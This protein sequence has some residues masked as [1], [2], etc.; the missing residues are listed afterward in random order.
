MKNLKKR[1]CQLNSL[2]LVNFL[3]YGFVA[4]Q[5]AVQVFE[6][7]EFN[8]HDPFEVNKYYFSLLPSQISYLV[9]VLYSSEF[10]IALPDPRYKLDFKIADN[11]E[12]NNMSDAAFWGSFNTTI[13]D[14][15][16][17]NEA[18]GKGNITCARYYL[19]RKK[20]PS[21]V[22]AEFGI[23]ISP[24]YLA[25]YANNLKLLVCY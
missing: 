13:Y 11:L 24:L 4:S 16:L 10:K 3:T 20:N 19:A 14:N 17:F 1:I 8:L 5:E 25:L 21:A 15:K 6:H 12:Q 9:L 23:P 18:F 22:N 7:E 2:I